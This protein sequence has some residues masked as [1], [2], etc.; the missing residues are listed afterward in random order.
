MIQFFNAK[1][2]AKNWNSNRYIDLIDAKLFAVEKEIEFCTKKVYSITIKSDFYILTDWANA[3]T[4]LEK[5]E[6]RTHSMNK[7][8]RNCEELHEIV[9]RNGV[10]NSVSLLERAPITTHVYGGTAQLSTKPSVG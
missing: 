6:F 7:I 9:S 5:F 8:H 10:T 3:I 1:T 2:K 4:R